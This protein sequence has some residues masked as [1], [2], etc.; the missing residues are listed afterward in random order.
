MGVLGYTL[1][2][3]RLLHR[4]LVLLRQ[5]HVD[6]LCRI[7]HHR[8][9]AERYFR[10]DIVYA[11]LVMR[12]AIVCSEPLSVAAQSGTAVSLRN[13][14]AGL[15][16]VGCEASLLAPRDRAFGPAI[17]RRAIF[18][19]RFQRA[20]SAYDVVVGVNGD[21]RQLAEGRVPRYVA[22]PK[23]VFADVLRFERGTSRIGLSLQA[24]WEGSAARRARTV[25]VSSAY[26]RSRVIALYDASPDRVFVVPDAFAS[27]AWRAQLPRAPRRGNRVLCVAHLYPRKRVIDLVDAWP[28]VLRQRPD[29]ELEIVGQGPD[30]QSLRSRASGIRQ[31]V[32]RGHVP[33]AELLLAYARADVFCLPSAQENFGVVALEALSAGLPV[34]VADG[35]ALPSTVDGAIAQVVPVGDPGALAGAIVWGL[36][37]E[38]RRAAGRN[39]PQVAGRYEPASVASKFLEILAL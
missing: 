39:N 18:N 23:A 28:S 17:V 37:A 5:M 12:L 11:G 35:G 33:R 24:R 32:F 6:F 34:V 20:A 15:V 31:C 36:Q 27:E 9:E 26:A 10:D 22:M 16:E 29:A 13:L 3:D 21:A 30:L 19:L 7:D 2:P 38:V 25:V 1:E 4:R 14:H 8:G